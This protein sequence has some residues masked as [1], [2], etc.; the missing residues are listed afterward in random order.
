MYKV[1]KYKFPENINFL[2]YPENNC[3]SRHFLFG[4]CNYHVLKRTSTNI[5]CGKLLRLERVS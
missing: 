5:S 1:S 2:E 3:H 4:H